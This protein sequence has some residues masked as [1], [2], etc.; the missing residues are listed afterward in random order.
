MNLLFD[1]DIN[2]KDRF[3][4]VL[5]IN[6]VS[7]QKFG[8]FIEYVKLAIIRYLNNC[9][10]TENREQIRAIAARSIFAGNRNIWHRFRSES[11]NRDS[12][13]QTR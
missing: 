3:E 12:G 7:E 4:I 8:D 2:N 5:L 13:D 6:A 11:R 9:K 10:N 1:K